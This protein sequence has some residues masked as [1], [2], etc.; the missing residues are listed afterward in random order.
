[1]P[2]SM[3][4]LEKK[5]EILVQH[6]DWPMTDISDIDRLRIEAYSEDLPQPPAPV[7]V[8]ASDRGLIGPPASR[9]RSRGGGTKKRV[10]RKNKTKKPKKPKKPKK[11][12]K[13][14]KRSLLR[15]LFL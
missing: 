15:K 1:M 3:N 12:S 10:Y 6:P 11:K 13:T 2:L 4:E 7:R 8:P 14:K 9:R 5:A